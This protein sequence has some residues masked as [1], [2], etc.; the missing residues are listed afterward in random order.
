MITYFEPIIALHY[1]QNNPKNDFKITNN[2]GSDIFY[3]AI[4]RIG[5]KRKFYYNVF[6]E[7]IFDNYDEEYA[8][9]K[10]IVDRIETFVPEDFTE[11]LINTGR[12]RRSKSRICIN[13]KFCFDNYPNAREQI[14][15]G[16]IINNR[17]Y[18]ND[19]LNFIN[20]AVSEP[21]FYNIG[22][23]SLMKGHYDLYIYF[24]K[25]KLYEAPHTLL[26]DPGLLSRWSFH[27]VDPSDTMKIGHNIINNLYYDE[28]PM[29]SMLENCL[30]SEFVTCIK[31]QSYTPIH[32]L[33][34]EFIYKK[35]QC[36]MYK[37]YRTLSKNNN[38]LIN[39]SVLAQL[40]NIINPLVTN[41]DA[42]EK[43]LNYSILMN[44]FGKMLNLG[45][46]CWLKYYFTELLNTGIHPDTV[47]DSVYKIWFNSNNKHMQIIMIAYGLGELDIHTNVI[48]DILYTNCMIQ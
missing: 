19:S 14:K 2:P 44:I 42:Y 26:N 6:G 13:L 47:M 28:T 29:I 3:C 5:L 48:S 40:E 37:I 18:S 17:Y 41:R 15:I 38:K 22:L 33:I 16:Q 43:D 1:L 11:I 34:Y 12:S 35:Q 30:I 9:L 27:N 31:L 45:Q 32:R 20:D 10:N 39:E 21:I 36:F 46:R 25:N 8:L 4:T 24:L 23:A 7:T